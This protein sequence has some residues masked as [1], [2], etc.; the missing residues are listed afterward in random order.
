MCDNFLK[1]AAKKDF[2]RRFAAIIS[3][4]SVK[5]TL[6]GWV[7]SKHTNR[8]F[9][10]TAKQNNQ[11]VELSRN[12]KN[13]YCNQCNKI[14]HQS[15]RTMDHITHGVLPSPWDMEQVRIVVVVV[16]AAAAY[17]GIVISPCRTGS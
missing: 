7:N 5:K 6:C 4:K 1:I 9:K 13:R 14:N 10:F 15:R 16:A 3:N 2:L 8:L 12:V 11:I 17:I